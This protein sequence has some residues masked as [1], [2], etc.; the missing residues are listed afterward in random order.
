MT[1]K[2]SIKRFNITVLLIA[3]VISISLSGLV[4]WLH[5]Q[6]NPQ[7]SIYRCDSAGEV[8]GID[9]FMLGFNFIY[10]VVILML[11]PTV[12]VM[13]IN[14]IFSWRKGADR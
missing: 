11:V 13:I 6:H 14:L 10:R 4:T 2:S 1:K 9:Y 12:A 7:G 3:L 5:I 8:L